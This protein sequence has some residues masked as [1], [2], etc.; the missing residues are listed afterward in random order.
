MQTSLIFGVGIVGAL[1]PEI[2]RLYSLRSK[3]GQSFSGFYLVISILFAALGGVVALILPA[4]TLW[5]AFYAG[6]STPVVV[7]TALKRGIDKDNK[8]DKEVRGPHVR[9]TLRGPHGEVSYRPSLA[10]FLNA[11]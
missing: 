3:G 4:T 5:A 6:I 9:D 8:D 7:T 1:A 2:V 11:L 10:R